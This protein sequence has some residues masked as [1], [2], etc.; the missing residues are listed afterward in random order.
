MAVVE[1]FV[2]GDLKTRFRFC[3][4]LFDVDLDG[5]VDKGEVWLVLE[6]FYRLYSTEEINPNLLTKFVDF[7]FDKVDEMHE[8]EEERKQKEQPEAPKSN[9]R[10]SLTSST[11][12]SESSGEQLVVKEEE[13]DVVEKD[14]GKKNSNF[15]VSYEEVCATIIDVPLFF[16]FVRVNPNKTQIVSNPDIRD[17]STPPPILLNRNPLDSKRNSL[18]SKN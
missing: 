12:D 17:R 16:E 9:E 3:W 4:D 18:N 11:S 14:E 5:K 7:L 10:E 15:K 6:A 1:K 13:L 8:I 2:R